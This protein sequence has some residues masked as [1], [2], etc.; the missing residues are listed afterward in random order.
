M[1][2]GDFVFIDE[3]PSLVASKLFNYHKMTVQAKLL[4]RIRQAQETSFN[5]VPVSFIQEFLQSRR[6]LDEKA[7]HELSLKVE[8]RELS[9]STSSSSMR[10]P[11][12]QRMMFKS[13][14]YST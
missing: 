6:A 9:G 11:K 13:L 8:P 3:I 10:S 4:D 12:L 2:L 7:L 5:L 1:L 14:V